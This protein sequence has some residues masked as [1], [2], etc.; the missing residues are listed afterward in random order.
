MFTMSVV[1]KNTFTHTMLSHPIVKP[2][3]FF[4]PPFCLTRVLISL[5]DILEEHDL[6]FVLVVSRT[7]LLIFV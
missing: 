7:P 2:P 1:S 6:L 4:S 5:H 3:I